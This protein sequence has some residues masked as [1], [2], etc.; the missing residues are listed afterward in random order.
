MF[1]TSKKTLLFYI[2]NRHF[3]K[4]MVEYKKC[5]YFK[6]LKKYNGI[7]FYCK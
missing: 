7:L 4:R 6:V 2:F 3:I 5:Y 1:I